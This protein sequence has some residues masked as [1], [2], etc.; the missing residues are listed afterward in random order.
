M[1]GIWGS[2]GKGALG[3]SLGMCRGLVYRKMR[4]KTP[5]ASTYSLQNLAVGISVV[6]VHSSPAR[7][8]LVPFYRREL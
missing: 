7:E 2:Q 6:V 1:R 3:K 5:G 4:K 8:T